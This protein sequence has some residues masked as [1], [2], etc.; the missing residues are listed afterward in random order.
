MGLVW[1]ELWKQTEVAGKAAKFVMAQR[2]GHNFTTVK[3]AG[4]LFWRRV[5]GRALGGQA[6]PPVPH[7]IG[8]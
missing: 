7:Q 8:S 2:A 6:E 4:L 1:M 5:M 3:W